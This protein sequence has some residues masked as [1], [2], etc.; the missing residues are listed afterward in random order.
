MIPTK[1]AYVVEGHSNR[2]C[3]NPFRK[4][5]RE[6]CLHLHRT[7]EAAEICM[8]RMNKMEKRPWRWV[9]VDCRV[10]F[11]SSLIRNLAFDT[12][13]VAHWFKASPREIFPKRMNVVRPWPTA[14]E[15]GV[16]MPAAAG[17]RETPEIRA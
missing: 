14:A 6:R 17:D 9:V 11:I 13:A 7:K 16:R 5:K 15:R 10:A 8:R 3:L 1:H 4:R 2:A 12:C